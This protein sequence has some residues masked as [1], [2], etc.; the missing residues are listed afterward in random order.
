MNKKWR[1]NHI[2][3]Y[4]GHAVYKFLKLYREKL[5]NVRRKSQNRDRNEVTHILRR[6]PNVD[7]NMLAGKYP[8]VDIAKIIKSD[9]CRGHHEPLQ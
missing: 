6:Y 2:F 3:H 1:E 4:K 5:Y 8:K 9:K 7:R